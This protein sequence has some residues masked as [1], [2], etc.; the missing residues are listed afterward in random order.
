MLIIWD[1]AAVV[2]S[3]I[4]LKCLLLVCKDAVLF[5]NLYLMTLLRL[6]DESVGLS[7]GFLDSVRCRV[8]SECLFLFYSSFL[9][10][11]P[12]FPYI[13]GEDFHSVVEWGWWHL[14]APS[15]PPDSRVQ[16]PAFHRGGLC[17]PWAFCKGFYHE[18]C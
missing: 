3:L 15:P 8:A 12:C 1:A 11:C 17:A 5:I 2:I 16:L 18:Q 10:L 14:Q 4:C 13:T 7:V 9:S 6:L